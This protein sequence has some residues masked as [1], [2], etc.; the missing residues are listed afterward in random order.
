MQEPCAGGVTRLIQAPSHGLA[1]LQSVDISGLNLWSWCIST[2]WPQLLV[3][4]R[5]FFLWAGSLTGGASGDPL[6]LRQFSAPLSDRHDLF[7]HELPRCQQT[8]SPGLFLQDCDFVKAVSW[9]LLGLCG[10]EERCGWQEQ[11]SVPLNPFHLYGSPFFAPRWHLLRQ[12]EGQERDRC[13]CSQ[14]NVET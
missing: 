2:S 10:V 3:A 1:P 12:V 14:L 5:C 4:L 7:S 9:N 8:L 6:F 11:N 13:S